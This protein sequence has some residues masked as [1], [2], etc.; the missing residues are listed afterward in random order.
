[1]DYDIIPAG[2]IALMIAT[3]TTGYLGVISPIIYLVAGIVL[4]YWIIIMLIDQFNDWLYNRQL[5]AEY[6]ELRKE[7]E[8]ILGESVL[9]GELGQERSRQQLDRARANSSV[10][11]KTGDQLLAENDEK[12]RS[13]QER[14]NRR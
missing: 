7:R 9:E 12:M 5:V 13:V 1:M 11:V 14:Y 6:D 3:S 2:D 10:V 4:A 8:S